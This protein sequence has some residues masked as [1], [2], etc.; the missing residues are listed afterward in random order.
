[1]KDRA[2]QVINRYRTSDGKEHKTFTEAEK[3]VE[4][5]IY[6]GLMK[7]LNPIAQK[8]FTV[9]AVL[10]ALMEKREDLYTLLKTEHFYE[11]DLTHEDID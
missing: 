2:W 6:K 11:D 5:N 3:H 9:H 7:I 8:N 1:M 4:N 10:L